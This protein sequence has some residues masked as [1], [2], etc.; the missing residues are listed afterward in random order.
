[1]RCFRLKHFV[2]FNP[3]GTVSRCGHMVNPPRFAT[4]DDM[5]ASRWLNEVNNK[6]DNNE[7]PPECIRCRQTEEINQ[8]SIRLH[9]NNFHELQTKED[10]L[11]VGGVLDNVCNSACQTCNPN[12]STK[13]GSL[14]NKNYPIVDN[15]SK[16]WQLPQDRIT[17]LDING[18]EP[19]ASKNYKAVLAN[20][21]PNVKSIRINTN[22]STVIPE[23]ESLANRGIEVTVTVSFDGI[24][25]YHDY[26]RWPILWTKFHANLL[27]YKEMKLHNL[28]LWTT[29]CALNIN[30]LPD[31]FEFARTN[32]I[33]HSYALLQNPDP[34]NIKYAN[35]LT[36]QAKEKLAGHAIANHIAI[37]KDN[38]EE[39]EVYIRTQDQLRGINIETQ[40][41]QV[42]YGN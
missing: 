22:C 39:L 36:L 29:V 5:D 31:I 24:G 19:S 18:G 21:P 7:F 9:N 16:F 27:R 13:I 35:G 42:Y 32:N 3:D 34:L 40:Y 2:R 10:Y 37:E 15:T 41:Q 25:E 1:M 8:T 20:P 23:L 17:H 38:T 26:I 6:F 4:L 28:N 33:D 14:Y 30:N 12:C 11:I